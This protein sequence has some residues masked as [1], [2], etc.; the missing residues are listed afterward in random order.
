MKSTPFESG[1]AMRSEKKPFQ[2]KK[3]PKPFT[4]LLRLLDKGNHVSCHGELL[5]QR[6]GDER[7]RGVERKEK[8]ILDPP[9]NVIFH[10]YS[11][12]GNIRERQQTGSGLVCVSVR[13]VGCVRRSK[14][15]QQ[16]A[17][18]VSSVET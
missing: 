11:P 4:K 16:S 7:E 17:L 3:N 2:E 18:P 9:C 13:R 12:A 10:V 1:T 6:R 15:I 8:K 5:Q 14:P